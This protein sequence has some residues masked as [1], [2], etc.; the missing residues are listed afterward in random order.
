MSKTKQIQLSNKLFSK[1][2]ITGGK[3]CR[4]DKKREN[5]SGIYNTIKENRKCECVLKE[6]GVV[7]MEYAVSHKHRNSIVNRNTEHEDL[8]TIVKRRKLRWYGHVSHLSGLARHSKRGKKRR[9]TLEEVRRHQGMDRPG[10]RQVPEGSGEQEKMEE[11]GC[12][13]IRGAPTT[14]TVNG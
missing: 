3:K 5:V 10:V 4:W 14:L 2:G 11:T 6:K 9:K 12:K 7:E 8:L 1:C 13:I